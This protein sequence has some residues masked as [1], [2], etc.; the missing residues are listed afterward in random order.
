MLIGGLAG[1]SSFPDTLAND[2]RGFITSGTAFVR[3]EMGTTTEGAPRVTVVVG[4]GV[5]GTAAPAYLVIWVGTNVHTVSE[6]ATLIANVNLLP[7]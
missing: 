6:A 3:G 1:C 2:I 4:G 5:A 7:I